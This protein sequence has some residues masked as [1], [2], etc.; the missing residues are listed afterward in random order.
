MASPENPDSA[1]EHEIIIE[2]TIGGGDITPKEASR[3]EKI[4]VNAPDDF[5]TRM[6]LLGYYFRLLRTNKRKG[7][8]K[9][10]HVLW[11]INN[12]PDI[13]QFAMPLCQ[14][15]DILEPDSFAP[16]K[17][18]WLRKLD[19]QPDNP[20]LLV[21]AFRFFQLSDQQF[22]LS[23]LERAQS[24][25]PDNLKIESELAHFYSRSADGA[26][27]VKKKLLHQKA[28]AG[29]E[30]LLA[31][32]ADQQER[33]NNL[34]DVATTAYEVGYMDRA[35]AV[36]REMLESAAKLEK[37][38]NTGNAIYWANIVLGKI[39]LANGEL[40]QSCTYLIC[41][42]ETCGSPQLDSFGPEFELCA[43]LANQGRID[44]SITYL[45]NCSK[46]WKSSSGQL[47]KWQKQLKNGIVPSFE[48]F[49]P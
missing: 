30:R 11:L 3:L 2:A 32:D 13:D 12:R 25:E 14:L 33:F 6:K 37:N 4:L 42:S 10:N 27:S 46:F 43:S 1:A 34:T 41:A 20:K 7:A 5:A 16:A 31:A 47:R 26:D 48:E 45:S 38:W 9:L 28:L 17:E 39:S 36:S 35:E 21:N 8:M 40:D 24:I 23:L 18:A 19:Q 29:F 15:D 44:A 49:D 22:A